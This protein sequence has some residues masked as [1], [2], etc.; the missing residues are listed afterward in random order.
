MCRSASIA[1]RKRFPGDPIF[2]VEHTT[3][4]LLFALSWLSS[5]H[6]RDCSLKSL[7]IKCI[8][9][10]AFIFVRI[11]LHIDIRKQNNSYHQ[12][13]FFVT[14]SDDIN[15]IL[16]WYRERENWKNG[17]NLSLARFQH[18]WFNRQFSSN[19]KTLPGINFNHTKY[20]NHTNSSNWF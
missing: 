20:R 19:V 4:I 1:L 6:T 14:K 12:E 11:C 3:R 8:D 15:T 13:S 18:S 7:F 17:L 9:L 5:S 16:S 10:C 2:I